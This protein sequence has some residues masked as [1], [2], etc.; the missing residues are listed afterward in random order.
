MKETNQKFNVPIPFFQQ[1]ID[2]NLRIKLFDSIMNGYAK[3]YPNSTRILGYLNWDPNENYYFMFSF[4]IKNDY[5]KEFVLFYLAFFGS[6]HSIPGY[7]YCI[8]HDLVD[9]YF[10]DGF[11]AMVPLETKQFENI[12]KSHGF[13]LAKA[14]DNYWKTRENIAKLI[15][16]FKNISIQ[17]KP[18]IQV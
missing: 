18:Q 4:K 2:K 12:I 9:E 8:T 5:G 6:R 13:S 16:H 1:K 14:D 7:Y 11:A 17:Y 15:E 10:E 3:R